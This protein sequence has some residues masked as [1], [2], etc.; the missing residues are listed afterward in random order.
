MK[1]RD[2]ETEAK[3]VLGTLSDFQSVRFGPAAMET[4]KDA[5]TWAM[6]SHLAALAGY[7]AIPFANISRIGIHSRFD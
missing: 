7:T 1:I 6:F 3:D 2:R 4:N 5:Q